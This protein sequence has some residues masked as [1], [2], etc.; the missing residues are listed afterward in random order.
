VKGLWVLLV[1]LW[2]EGVC[3]GILVSIGLDLRHDRRLR[4]DIGRRITE[5]TISRA[6]W[7]RELGQS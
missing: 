5:G 3:T 2:A 7:E 6:Q 4:E 1:L